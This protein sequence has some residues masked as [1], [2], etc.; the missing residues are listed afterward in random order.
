MEKICF[1]NTKEQLL[2]DAVLFFRPTINF[3][4]LKTALRKK[5]IK[6]NGQR[7]K[8]NIFLKAGDKVELYIKNK[9]ILYTH[10]ICRYLYYLNEKLLVFYT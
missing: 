1:E 6:V 7:I 2:F 4:I 10:S 5:D 8:E 9:H 3:N